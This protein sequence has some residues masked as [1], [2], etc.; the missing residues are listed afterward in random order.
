MRQAE[1]ILKVQELF[2]KQEFVNFDDMC[3]RFKASKS[4]IRR[5]LMDLEQKGILRRVHGGAISLQT[6]DEVMDFGR[7]SGSAHDEKTRIGR[8][9]ASLVDEGQTVIL[10]GGSTVAEVAKGLD[11]KSI[12]IIT[13]SIPVA[14][15]FW[16]SKLVEVTLTGGYLYPRLGVQLGP[17]C[18]KML[19]SVSADILIMGIRGITAAGLSDSNFLIVESIRAMIKVARKVVIVA[20][21]SKFGR[22]AMT[23]VA[24]LSDVDVVVTDKKLSAEFQQM[25]KDQNVDVLLA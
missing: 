10:G 19:N 9:A 14:Q 22:D 21:H 24:S 4:S 17:I 12:Q 23:H 15:I 13:N 5:D 20:D 8:L 7:L 16:D 6:R 18:E 25:L 11:S 3:E 2:S 1:R